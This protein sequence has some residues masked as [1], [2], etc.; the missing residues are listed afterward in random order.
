ME[1][2]IYNRKQWHT[3]YTNVYNRLLGRLFPGGWE[4]EC[5]QKRTRARTMEISPHMHAFI[6]NT[7]DRERVA[8]C[9]QI[10]TVCRDLCI[11][12]W[13]KTK[14]ND[15]DCPTFSSFKILVTTKIGFRLHRG[16]I[17]KGPILTKLEDPGKV[18]IPMMCPTGGFPRRASLN[19]YNMRKIAGKRFLISQNSCNT[20][21][22]GKVASFISFLHLH[23]SSADTVTGQDLW[24]W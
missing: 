12:R 10:M 6:A 16:N 20:R 11:P 17:S 19:S 14:R 4:E 8:S 5:G 1:T 7:H 9:K 23:P 3:F 24:G 21:R 18:N 13:T 22:A 15:L 2:H